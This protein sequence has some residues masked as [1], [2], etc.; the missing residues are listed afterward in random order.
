MPILP[1]CQEQLSRFNGK[2][3]HY[4]AMGRTMINA[5]ATPIP[6]LPHYQNPKMGEGAEP[7]ETG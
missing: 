3:K 4:S 2:E 6:A 1:V 7:E 5:K